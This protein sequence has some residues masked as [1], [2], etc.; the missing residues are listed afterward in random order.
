MVRVAT[1]QEL[2]KKL[3]GISVARAGSDEVLKTGWPAV[4]AALG[5]G[6]LAGA[7]HEWIGVAPP[8]QN[9]PTD[10]DDRRALSRTWSPPLCVLVHLA[11]QALLASSQ[12][13]WTV[14][15]GQRCFPYP[16]VLVRDRGADR[17]LLDRSLFITPHNA[18]SRL[19]AADIAL[20]S[21]SVGAVIADGNTFSMAATRR[22]QLLAKEH[23]TL[24]L[25]VRPFWEQGELS[26]A[27]SRWHIRWQGPVATLRKTSCNPQWS[28]RLL[29]Y[30]GAQSKNIHDRWTLEWDSGAGALNL[31][32]EVAHPAR[33]TKDANVRF[34]SQPTSQTA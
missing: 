32:T 18:E 23:R 8:E 6:L 31:S 1:I 16:S 29:R 25:M 4:D 11:W 19:W 22:I 15:V 28:V 9:R 5:G 21:P 14:W 3:G 10:G 7:L 20:R 34:R 30:K 26:A 27:H 12:P 2:R 17:R 33:A 13:R 24:A